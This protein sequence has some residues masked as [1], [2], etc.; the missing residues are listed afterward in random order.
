MDVV[1]ERCAGLD[2]HKESVF[3]CVRIAGAKGNG[4]VRNFRTMTED[5]EQ[6]RDWLVAE[7]VTHVAMESTGVYWRPIWNVL[8]DH[9][10][11][12][13]CNA[14]QVKQVPGRKTDVRDCE[15]L[16]KLLQHGLLSP[17]FVPEREL[18]DLRDLTRY[19]VKLVGQQTAEANR[20]QALL[21]D[22]NIK[23]GDVAS[24]VLGASGRAMLKAMVAGETDPAKLANLAK[25]SLRTKIPQLKKALAGKL[26]D[27]HR[28]LLAM[29]LEAVHTVE[30][31]I[32]KLDGRIAELTGQ[33]PTPPTHDG[34]SS[35]DSSL[36]E[37]QAPPSTDQGPR[38]QGPPSMAEAIRLVAS[39]PGVSRKL[40]EDI[41][42]EIGADMSRFRSPAALAS[43]A[44][45]CPGNNESAGKKRH[46]RTTKGSVWLRRALG[47]AGAC[48]ARLKDSFLATRYRR[49]SKRRGKLRAVVAAGHTILRVIYFVLTHRQPYQEL[50][51]DHHDRL[52][53]ARQLR[54]H[55]RRVTELKALV[56]PAA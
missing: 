22:A 6:L 34:S 17:S 15:W 1:F 11:L 50:G 12:L 25:K 45:M 49:I 32:A 5:L 18:R 39:V 36:A 41:L 3:A 7:Q 38:A 42:A 28:F 23:L 20:V 48:S 29:H 43:W 51:A 54:Y 27:H 2:V 30:A 10:E 14:K 31:G 56:V 47:I 21:E 24:D 13:L 53:T 4:V 37:Q 55:E 44:G 52:N 8:E 16:A 19:R 46:G 9:F 26:T 40:A 33:N 35:E